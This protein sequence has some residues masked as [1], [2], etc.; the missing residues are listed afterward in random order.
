MMQLE[1]V[2]SSLNS[3]Q[4]ILDGGLKLKVFLSLNSY[5]DHLYDIN[6]SVIA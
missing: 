2:D 4:T 5:K 6:H 1:K 3:D